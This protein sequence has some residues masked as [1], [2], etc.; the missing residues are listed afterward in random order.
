MKNE[1][2]GDCF[3]YPQRMIAASIFG[4][5]LVFIITAGL[6]YGSTYVYYG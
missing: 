2:I 3:Y 6:I 1:S 4:V 5:L